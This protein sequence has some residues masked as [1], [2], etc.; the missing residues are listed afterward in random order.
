M[1][2]APNGFCLENFPLVLVRAKNP[3]NNLTY[4]VFDMKLGK[5]LEQSPGELSR[6][7]IL[8]TMDSVDSDCQDIYM[9]GIESKTLNKIVILKLTLV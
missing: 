1:L 9:F 2:L 7:L 5:H 4:R 3:T 8:G 6:Y